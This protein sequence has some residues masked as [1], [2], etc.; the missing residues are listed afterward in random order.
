MSI[1]AIADLHASRSDPETGLPIKPMDVF[2]EH[3]VNHM[4]RIES[5][6]TGL[7]QPGDTVI[8]AGDID[9]GLRPDE[10]SETID[11]LAS[12]P[13]AKLL[14]R[15]NHDYWWSSKSTNKLRRALPPGVALI[16]N[17]AFQAEGFNICGTKGSPVP[18][19]IDWTPDDAKILARE[20][21]RLATSLSNR[22]HALPTIVA[23]H[24]PPF[25]VGHPDS[26]YRDAIRHAGAAAC[27]YGH[28]HSDASSSGPL[29]EAD[30]TVYF[31]VAADAV[32]FRPVLIASAG[33]LAR[34]TVPLRRGGN[35]HG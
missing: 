6:W 4:G 11:R 27:V 17:N 28:L 23:L 35:P 15:G 20:E 10:A 24:H 32:D 18:G 22:D 29:G 31:L 14:V 3:W 8:V 21:Q 34:P 25:F 7:V 26:P 9:W 12:L 1:W 30:G 5:A 2:G 19:S 33:R 16:H 13:G